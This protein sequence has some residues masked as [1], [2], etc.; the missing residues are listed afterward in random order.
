M[1]APKNE[2]TGT[3][4][5]SE[6]KAEFERLGWGVMSGPEHDLGTDLLL[7]PRDDRRFDL[8]T[9][10]GA[11]VKTGPSLFSKTYKEDEKIV[12][13][14][15]STD[16][17]HF[18]YWSNHAIPHI[19]ILRNQDTNTSYWQLV[20]RDN[21]RYTGKTAKILIPRNQTID[22]SHN[23]DLQNA[24]LSMLPSPVWEGSA[25]RGSSTIDR[26]SLIRYA[27]LVPRMVATNPHGAGDIL[28]GIEALALQVLMNDGFNKLFTSIN[29]QKLMENDGSDIPS[30]EEASESSEWTWQATAALYNYL[31][32]GH[33]DQI[34]HLVSHSSTSN[35]RA[36]A[37]VLAVMMYFDNND[38][39]SALTC[40]D[41]ALKHDDYSPVDYA[42]LRAQKSRALLELGRTQDAYNIANDTIQV[43]SNYP[44]DITASAIA[45]AC[46]I[47]AFYAAGWLRGDTD[48]VKKCYDNTAMWWRSELVSAGLSQHLSEEF[49]TWT[50]KRSIRF[51]SRDDSCARLRS[52]SLV[53]SLT[54][55][56]NGWRDAMKQ[57]G[58]HIL[59]TS[60]TE[61]PTERYVSALS[62]LRLA[63]DSDGAYG[64]AQYLIDQVDAKIG[65]LAAR[66]ITLDSSTRT[67]ALADIK[68]LTACGDVL[69]S[70][71]ANDVCR[72]AINTLTDSSDY[73][74]R[75]QPVFDVFSH[76]LNMIRSLIPAL[77]EKSI[78]SIIDYILYLPVV[79]DDGGEAQLLAKLVYAVPKKS[80]TESDRKRALERYS[81]DAQFLR[82]ALLSVASHEATEEIERRACAGDLMVLASL[83]SRMQELSETAA[84]C[85]ISQLCKVIDNEIAQAH[86]GILDIQ[87]YIDIGGA[88]TQLSVLFP[89]YA[90]WDY[91]E[92]RLRTLPPTATIHTGTLMAIRGAGS[93]LTPEVKSD[94]IPC[95]ESIYRDDRHSNLT[96]GADGSREL[97]VEALATISD[98]S[99][100]TRLVNELLTHGSDERASAAWIISHFGQANQRETLLGLL[101]DS[102]QVV[103]CAALYGLCLDLLR[104]E[105]PDQSVIDIVANRLEHG[106]RSTGRAIVEAMHGRK[107]QEIPEQLVSIARHHPC[108]SVRNTLNDSVQDMQ[109]NAN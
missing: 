68:L 104:S 78:R 11:Q 97:A 64:T 63:G 41:D 29:R 58:Q 15:F 10:M 52:A 56:Q 76:L 98:A 60:T 99:T 85:L 95:L 66:E 5:E 37:H 35:E 16:L 84:D 74:E 83:D 21:I 75:T 93:N 27:L 102:D 46:A 89:N 81:S 31:H 80:W 2:A 69:E 42:W 28:P 77:D 36:A 9:I 39:K 48:I 6:V 101:H 22:K 109:L 103:Q 65:R 79:T 17:D 38:A 108:A 20:T 73:I 49:R 8:R 32:K 18:E 91:I 1:R 96:F 13:W 7:S 50:N 105:Y 61:S 30:L 43:R 82:E 24:A 72:W 67:T 53:S 87:N 23:R 106:T 34:L 100:R 3:S 70:R 107:A 19:I 40:V 54:G 86:N 14:W 94:L 44:T 4:G 92:R 33:S 47:T 88:L 45:G 51:G 62:I 71:Q 59:V 57:L 26:E 90:C 25:W 55:D 12:G